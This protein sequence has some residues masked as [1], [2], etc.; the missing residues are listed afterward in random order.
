M[1]VVLALCSF[2]R[3]VSRLVNILYIIAAGYRTAYCS[4]SVG[5]EKVALIMDLVVDHIINVVEET[6]FKFNAL[7][8]FFMQ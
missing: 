8:F 7:Y 6:E 4:L 1:C 2:N 3:C 5:L